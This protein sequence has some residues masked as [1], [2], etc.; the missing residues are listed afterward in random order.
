MSDPGRVYPERAARDPRGSL[1][2]A[3]PAAVSRRRWHQLARFVERAFVH[4]DE[5]RYDQTFSDRQ[6]L[7]TNSSRSCTGA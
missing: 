3:G 5:G 2:R 6:A 1:S 4:R 7:R